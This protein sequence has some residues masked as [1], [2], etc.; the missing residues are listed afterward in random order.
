MARR[1]SAIEKRDNAPAPLVSDV[2]E[3]RSAAF[4]VG[5]MLVASPL[6]LQRIVARVPA[7]RV[8][9]TGALRAALATRFSADYTCPLTTGIFLR[10][11][12]EAAEE[13]LAFGKACALPWW[14]VVRDD[15]ALID[16]LPGG[17]AEQAKRLTADGVAV[18]RLRGVTK[19]VAALADVV[20]R[21]RRTR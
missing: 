17:V 15:G 1:K 20:W 14:R 7:G 10:V 13:E 2:H 9:T 11:I 16:R 4:P 5:R 18:A 19:R 21:P 8:L 3:S 6:E 12:A